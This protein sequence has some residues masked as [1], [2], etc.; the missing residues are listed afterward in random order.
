MNAKDKR[1]GIKCEE[2]RESK[3]KNQIIRVNSYES[4]VNKSAEYEQRQI[5]N[6]QAWKA[7]TQKLR[8]KSLE[9]QVKSQLLIIK[10][11]E[12]M[13]KNQMLVVKE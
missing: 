8:I 6:G 2:S 1:P 12:V 9:A 11:D 10:G 5:I 3:V 13:C 7:K 4:K